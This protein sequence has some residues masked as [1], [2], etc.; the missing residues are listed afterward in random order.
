[1]GVGVPEGARLVVQ[2]PFAQLPLGQLLPQLPSEHP[3]EQALPQ[4]LQPS[5]EETA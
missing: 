1:M 3:P 4:G 5:Q 2:L